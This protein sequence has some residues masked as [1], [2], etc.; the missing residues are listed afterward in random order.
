MHLTGMVAT[1]LFAPQH[2]ILEKQKGRPRRCSF[3]SG[4]VSGP[5]SRN[6]VR[7]RCLGACYTFSRAAPL[8]TRTQ[9]ARASPARAGAGVPGAV[10]RARVHARRVH[11]IGR[12]VRANLAVL[13]PKHH[14]SIFSRTPFGTAFSRNE[15]DRPGRSFL[16]DH[17]ALALFGRLRL[18]LR[19]PE[20]P[21]WA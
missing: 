12:I 3:E 8:T 5:A 11:R 6:L 7:F 10:D 21:L 18:R 1:E 4:H 15:K 17:S 14:R 16:G 20:P 13:N 9:E 2:S 19:R